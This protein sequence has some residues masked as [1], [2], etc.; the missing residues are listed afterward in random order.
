MGGDSDDAYHGIKNWRCILQ[1]EL[2]VQAF[3]QGKVPQDAQ[4][5]A[6]EN[7]RQYIREGKVKT[8]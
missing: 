1:Q 6:D 2:T 5:R 8:E 7:L 3:I 4:K